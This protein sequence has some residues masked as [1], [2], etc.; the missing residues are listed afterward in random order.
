VAWLNLRNMAVALNQLDEVERLGSD[1]RERNCTFAASG[2]PVSDVNCK[3]AANAT[4]PQCLAGADLTNIQYRR[5]VD[6]FNKAEKA[7]GQEQVNLYEESATLLVQAVDDEPDHPQAPLA[8]E[9]AAIAL[10]RTN[11]FESAARLYS[12][13]IDEV[14]PRK[15]KDDKEQVELD[16]ILANSYFRLAYNANRFFDYD[17]A[18]EN[19]RILA[20]SERFKKSQDPD[21]GERREGALINA[22]K[23][24]EYQQ[25][26]ARAADY[27]QRAAE[28]LKDPAE[29]MAANYRVAEMS[30]KQQKW[31]DTVTKMKDFIQRYQNDPAA[32]DL[33]VQAY[34]RVSQAK[35]ASGKQRDYDNALA[36]VVS[37]YAKS[38]QKPGSMAA[39]Y[40]A[41][42]KFLLVDKGVEQFESFEIKPGQPATMKAYVDDLKKQIERG[43][44]SAKERNDAYESVMA[45][46]RPQWTIAA[47]VRQGRT[48]E[49]LAKAVLNTPFVV[50]KDMKKQMAKL[51]DYAREDVR[52]Q[53]EDTVRQ[54][55]DQQTRP[56]E[57]FAVVRYALAARAGKV[58]SID[59]EYTQ[60]AITRLGAYGDERIA[61]CIAEQQ[62]KD[63]S[64]QAYTPG[65][66]ARA[67]RGAVLPMPVGVS[68]PSLEVR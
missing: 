28:S 32:G 54:L 35:K 29:K 22:A 2:R 61:E 27:Y 51:P 23:I 39:E 8:L 42:A 57:C 11:R 56:I 38:G 47:F 49:V 44:T 18:V 14:G 19:Y 64:L 21:M 15:A 48:Y 4:E 60:Q 33:V 53:V 67:P 10:E 59:N 30:F 6:V 62:T 46:R 5:A 26:Y 13:I 43:A 45:Y 68:P 17:R 36:D 24:L 65:E 50:P 40:A 9:K 55:L 31:S 16:A 25:Q 3:D 63:A 34:W 66:F 1:L 41:Q 52:V 37:G 12:R 7:K 58:G 20:D